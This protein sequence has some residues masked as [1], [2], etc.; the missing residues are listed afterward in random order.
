[1]K[2]LSWLM[3][4]ALMIAAVGCI[5]PRTTNTGRS[6]IE[7][8]LLAE[9]VERSVNNMS[10]AGFQGKKA[11]MDYSKL[12]PQVDKDYV[13]GVFETHLATSGIQVVEKAEDAQ[14][15]IRLLCGV[16]ATD[17]TELNIGT[18]AIPIPV[19]DANLSVVIPPLSI[20]KRLSRT[21]TC[22]LT[23]VIYDNKTG[24][25]LSA[26]RGVQSRTFYNNWVCLMIVPYV[27]R[28]IEVAETGDYTWVFWD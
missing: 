14:L 2:N 4:A 12:A 24:E 18:P 21:G 28:D 22:R 3:A 13:C 26:Y 5:D 11:V 10:F 7:Q 9:A 20:F 23:A 1:M 27:T 25:L 6:A 8:G 17:N 16:L 15:K 19:P